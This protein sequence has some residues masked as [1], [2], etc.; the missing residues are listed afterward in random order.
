MQGKS[1]ANRKQRNLAADRE[2]NTYILFS[3]PYRFLDNSL[4]KET[5]KKQ[6]HLKAE[7]EDQRAGRYFLLDQRMQRWSRTKADLHVRGRKITDCPAQ[8]IL[9]SK[10]LANYLA[11]AC[12]KQDCHVSCVHSGTTIRKSRIHAASV[13]IPPGQTYEKERALTSF[14]IHA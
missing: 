7:M 12:K 3:A 13:D 1:T 14:G 5:S 2:G 10:S 4:T 11:N 9:L 6:R 8:N